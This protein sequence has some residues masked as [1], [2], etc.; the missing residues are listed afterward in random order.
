MVDT[1]TP[2]FELPGFKGAVLRPDDEGYD[3]ARRVFNGMIGRRPAV[4]ARCTDG[5]DVAVVVNLARENDLPLSIYGGGHSVTGSAVVDAGIC[6]DLRSMKG[7]AVNPDAPPGPHARRS[8]RGG[9][10]PRLHHRAPR[11]LRSRAGARSASSRYHRGLRRP[12]RGGRRPVYLNYI[13][14]E[15]LGRVEAAFGPECYARLQALK[16]HRR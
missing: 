11:R 10:G 8:G 1:S 12:G 16:G 7:I 3:D 14:D 13:G 5:D 2:T 15:G 4:I 9:W 6:A